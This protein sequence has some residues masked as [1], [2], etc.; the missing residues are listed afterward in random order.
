MVVGGLSRS[1]GVRLEVGKL[2]ALPGVIDALPR[3]VEAGELD[4][5]LA[6]AAQELSNA[7][8]R[9]TGAR[10]RPDFCGELG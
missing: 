9:R 3:A 5:Q 4:A 6:G 10:R 1:P 7:L 8:K 2:E